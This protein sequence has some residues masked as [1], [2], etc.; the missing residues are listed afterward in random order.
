ML[1]SQ[2]YAVLN[3]F[4]KAAGMRIY[5]L[6]SRPPDSRSATRTVGSSE[7]L[8]ARTQPADPAPTTM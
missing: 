4:G 8:A 6:R 7:S 1:K 2:S 3:S 5:G